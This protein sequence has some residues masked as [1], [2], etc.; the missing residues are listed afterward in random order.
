MEQFLNVQNT[1]MAL[2]IVQALH[3]LHHRLA[4]RPIS[5]V[6]VATGLL[7][8]VTPGSV[9]DLDPL[10]PFVHLALCAVQ[11][12]GSLFIQKLSPNWDRQSNAGIG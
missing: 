1:Y 10:L 3:L 9:A 12:V 11:V 2:L 7:L 6:E 8:C 4:K 5:F